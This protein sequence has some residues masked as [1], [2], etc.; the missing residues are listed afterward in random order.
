MYITWVIDGPV[1]VNRHSRLNQRAKHHHIS[2]RGSENER[3]ATE[4]ERL[5]FVSAYC[6]RKR[7]GRCC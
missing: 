2:P 5:S 3:F 7:Y 1:R 4:V 6:N